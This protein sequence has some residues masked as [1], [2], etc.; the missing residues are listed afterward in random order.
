VVNLMDHKL[1]IETNNNDTGNTGSIFSRFRERL[2]KI[3]LFRSRKRKNEKF[4]KETVE[5][6]RKVFRE[7]GVVLQK[8]R[9]SEESNV[10]VEK[11][12]FKKNEKVQV[13]DE[14]T[15]KVL[16]EIKETASERQYKVPRVGGNYSE[17]IENKKIQ[18]ENRNKSQ[19]KVQNLVE[20]QNE[21]KESFDQRK[22]TLS[23]GEK[24]QN[25]EEKNI[26]KKNSY[27]KSSIPIRK[28]YGYQ[29]KYQTIGENV[30]L[31]SDE[32]KK[33]TL[34]KL[35]KEIITQIKENFL[36][37][38]DELE[39]L[40]SELYFIK[41]DQDNELELKK[42]KEIKKRI[43]ELIVEVN[44]IIEQY[45]LYHDNY[46]IDNVIGL[47]DAGLVEDMIDYRTMVES[48]EEEKK[49]VREFKLLDEFKGLYRNLVHIKGEA[50]QIIES[51][52]K[53]IEEFDIRDQ[54]YDKIKLEAVNV[55][56]MNKKCS[57]EIERQNHYFKELMKDINRINREEYMTYHLRG[58]GNLIG[59]SLRYMGLMLVSPFNGLIPGIA[60]STLATRRMI[61]NIYHNMRFEEVRHVHYDAVNYEF[62]L[63]HHLTNIIQLI[64]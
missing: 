37:K 7:E 32:E 4:I 15:F 41:K 63:N 55:E 11:E 57:L 56:E 6:I 45:N 29:E 3:K 2:R 31:M 9:V 62:E 42:V 50:E 59:Q 43:Q 60:A 38:L 44:E 17:E 12:K 1:N 14:S 19:E 20:H 22:N 61:G 51:N 24:I 33:E 54:K 34:N 49:I 18:E 5:E 10:Q 58:V 46:Y 26:D 52:E 36:E 16:D 35:G 40:E 25:S 23:T 47:D 39:V 21:I 28:K 8:T 48:Y 27:E 13:R 64:Y 30:S 53:K